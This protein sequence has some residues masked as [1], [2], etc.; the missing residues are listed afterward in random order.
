[1]SKKKTVSYK[2]I[3]PVI[4]GTI[5]LIVA[6]FQLYSL[7]ESLFAYLD[8]QQFSHKGLAIPLEGTYYG[9][10]MPD[11]FAGNSPHVKILP[12]EHPTLTLLFLDW[13]NKNIFAS[14]NMY[15][16]STLGIIPVITWEPWDAKLHNSYQADYTPKRIANGVYDDYIR[17][18][19]RDIAIY[20]KPVF[21]RFAHEMNGNWYPWGKVGKNTPQDYIAMWRHVYTIF[22]QEN[23]TNVLWVWSPNNTDSSGSVES[24]L[25][26]YPGTEFVDWVG[27]SAFNWG[28]QHGYHWKSFR[29]IAEPVYAKLEFLN[30]PIL[31]AEMSSTNVGGIKEQWFDETLSNGLQF[32]P[33]IKGV[34]FY[35]DNF[36]EYEFRLGGGMNVDTVIT[37]HILSN[38]YFLTQPEYQAR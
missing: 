3:K 5:F 32:F 13:G 34:V 10:Y 7:G 20:S 9:Y 29:E 8:R 31:V 15:S 26:Y 38:P 17:Q 11:L 33:N 24:L 12:Q 25:A 4:I 1:M 18:F 36:G 16:I 2:A 27:F 14:Q 19:A 37:K 22:E 28:E 23:A 6:S 35:N 21:L 30:K